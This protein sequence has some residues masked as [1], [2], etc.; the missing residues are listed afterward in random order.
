[1]AALWVWHDSDQ[2][3]RAACNN[4]RCGNELRRDDTRSKAELLLTYAKPAQAKLA[5]GTD[6]VPSTESLA[7][8][9]QCICVLTRHPP[10]SFLR[11]V[12]N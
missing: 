8:I 11:T 2:I 6:D 1:M 9:F 10:I 7:R 5:A 12:C 4:V 3:Q